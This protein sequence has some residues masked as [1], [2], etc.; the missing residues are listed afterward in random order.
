MHSQTLSSEQVIEQ[1]PPSLQRLVGFE[2]FYLHDTQRFQ[3]TTRDPCFDPQ[4]FPQN[5]GAIQLPCF[6]ILRKHLSVYGST[7]A[8]VGELDVFE[9]NEHNGRVLFPIHPS[10]LNYYKYFLADVKAE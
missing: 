8:G 10:S 7:A 2:R 5:C 6:W 4:Y 9:G 1:L 3:D